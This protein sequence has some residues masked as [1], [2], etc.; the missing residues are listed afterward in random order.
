MARGRPTGPGGHVTL[1]MEA[2]G[3]TKV[4]ER[5][6]VRHRALDGAS[7][8]VLSGELLAVMGR[9]GSG[10][11]TLLNVLGGIDRSHSG[12]VRLGDVRFDEC[13][14]DELA[15]VRRRSIGFVFQAFNLVP[16]LTALENVALP[17]VIDGRPPR[18]SEQRA[19]ELLGALGLADRADELPSRLS[20]GEQ[21]RVAIARALLLRP[22]VVLADE[23]TGNL[24]SE[25]GND[26][27]ELLRATSDDLGQTVVMV[28]HDAVAAS[29][30]DRVVHL[31]DG[32]VR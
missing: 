7:V 23:P 22:R 29:V 24:D 1:L 11:S 13:S 20:G 12:W 30:A 6:A 9:S 15:A 17:G 14:D 10:K 4:Y 8:Q 26:V 18:E 27:L 21:Q 19:R 5:G 32:V 2:E 25:S 3:V 28:T 31:D 16:V